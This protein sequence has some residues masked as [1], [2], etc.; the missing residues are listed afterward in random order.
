VLRSVPSLL[1]ISG[2]PALRVTLLIIN[3][4]NSVY[5]QAYIH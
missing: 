2:F 3:S 5:Q 1:D 4:V